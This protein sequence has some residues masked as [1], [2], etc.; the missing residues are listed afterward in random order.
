MNFVFDFT[1]V[2][3]FFIVVH[4]YQS[5]CWRVISRKARNSNYCGHP[6]LLEELVGEKLFS[7]ELLKA[8]EA[9]A[10]RLQTIIF[11]VKISISDIY[12]CIL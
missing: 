1:K 9:A 6:S 10:H 4:V 7:H 11:L 12:F 3:G 2:L 8:A 5:M